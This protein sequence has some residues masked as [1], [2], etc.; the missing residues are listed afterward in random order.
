MIRPSSLLKLSRVRP[1]VRRVLALD[2]GSRRFKLLLAES[3]F[4]RL[5]VLKEEL[6]D[7]QAE[8]LVAGEEIKA[9]L[10]KRLEEW[11]QPPLALV[12]PQHLCISQVL[13]LPLAPDSEVEKLIAD[14]TIKL[15]GVSE[16]R[17]VYDFVRT[18]TSR[19]NRQ[20][21]WVTFCQEG[22]IRERIA[23]LGV[24]QEELCEVTTTASA[25][26][27]AYRAA[28]PL[29]SRA[30]LVHL[31]AQATVVVIVLAGQ[32]AFATSFPMGGDFFTRALARQ[33]KC[34]EETAE[35]LKHEQ[36][37]FSGEFTAVVDGWVAELKRQLS[38]W[39]EHN[40]VAE[41]PKPGFL[42]SGEP[43][44]P[45]ATPVASGHAEAA[46]GAFEM[47]GSGGGF[48]QP[49]LLA[50]LKT[51]GLELEPWPGKGARSSGTAGPSQEEARGAAPVTAGQS[52]GPALRSRPEMVY[53]GKGF[54]I[55]F[56][57]AL[58]ALGYSPQPVSL[59]PEDYR[60][61]WQK[62][63]NRQRVELASA[64]LAILCFLALALGTWNKLSLIRTKTALWTKVQAGLHDV[65]ANEALTSELLGEYEKLRPIFAAQQNTT[66]TLKTLALLE[67]SRA[68][69][70]AWFVLLADQQSY[71]SRPPVVQ[72]NPPVRKDLLGLATETPR[73]SLAGYRATA[74]GVTNLAPAR[75]GLIAELC[76]PG[77]A[78]P[79][80]HTLSELVNGLKQ[81]ALFAKVDLLSDDLHRNLADPKVLVPDRHF[82][83]AL[84][85]AEAD[86]QQPSPGKRPAV[87]SSQPSRR[88][89]RSSRSNESIENLTQT[90]P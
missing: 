87:A 59:L 86:F 88:R 51:A 41:A 19:R 37:F 70:N 26:I 71:F 61:A 32:G 30:I 20:Q 73:P 69:R 78:E 1:P 46:V 77:E 66:D 82:V 58:Q 38:E 45:E 14:E 21:F 80:R 17:I 27:A 15:S 53:P 35:S 4:G 18:E 76:V 39:F 68:S 16:S 43:V 60:L 84:D 67:Q 23:G 85:F 34:S 42:T 29:S 10:Q 52:R 63:L 48:E 8:G 50:H 2:G 40:P 74:T 89:S 65:E 9:H 31:G 6:I 24:E 22:A 36:D 44:S 54:E 64:V 79:A 33:M 28:R 49:G 57:A 47:I 7:L 11:G 12:L 56:G 25:L 13:E 90:A 3:A 62:R 55:A 83:L 72:T 81:Q 5:R 75:P